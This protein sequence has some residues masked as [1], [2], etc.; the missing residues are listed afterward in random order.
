M[1]ENAAKTLLGVVHIY[2]IFNKTRFR[3]THEALV[4]GVKISRMEWNQV[5]RNLC[6]FVRLHTRSAANRNDFARRRNDATFFC[7]TLTLREIV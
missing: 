6:T 2:E 5:K 7:A 3:L 4:N 1:Q